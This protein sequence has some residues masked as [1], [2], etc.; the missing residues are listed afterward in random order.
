MVWALFDTNESTLS[1]SDCGINLI[2]ASY[3]LSNT[4]FWSS[5]IGNI[6]SSTRIDVEPVKIVS[7][8]LSF[9][10]DNS[11]TKTNAVAKTVKTILF[12]ILILNLEQM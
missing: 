9:L 3:W 7:S 1:F 2:L 4:I 11:A 6:D 5:A 10:Q 8:L 12:E